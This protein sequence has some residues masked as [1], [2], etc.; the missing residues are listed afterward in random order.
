MARPRSSGRTS[1]G[2]MLQVQLAFVILSE[3]EGYRSFLT[4]GW[5]SLG[6]PST[7]CP[8]F[9]TSGGLMV[10]SGFVST[11]HMSAHSPGPGQLLIMAHGTSRSASVA[12]DEVSRP[13]CHQGVSGLHCWVAS[14]SLTF[15]IWQR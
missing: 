12:Q 8:V 11:C 1:S 13:P 3:M 4:V 9:L 2:W 10:H 15:F 14:L 5:A 6:D 7:S